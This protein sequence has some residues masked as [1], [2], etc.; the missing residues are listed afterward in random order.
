MAM[1]ARLR[2]FLETNHVPYELHR[3]KQAHTAAAVAAADHV[4]QSEM[5]KVIILRSSRQYLMAVIPASRR[6]DL[7]RVR[8]VTD[9]QELEVANEGEVA[10]LFP[11]CETG[12]MPP[13]GNLFGIPVWVDDA[14]GRE[15]ETVFNAG[16]HRETIHMAY[17]DFV[18]IVRPSFA[19]LG[20]PR[21][22]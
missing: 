7:E 5:A 6:L 2:E 3:H 12:A 15:A 19:A 8:A 14:L 11:D 4:P 9:E 21:V 18:R 22:D 13:F 16:N 20:Q 17:A 10:D 1:M